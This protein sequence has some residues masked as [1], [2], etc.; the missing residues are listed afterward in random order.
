MVQ[1]PKIYDTFLG[2]LESLLCG[3]GAG[4]C[5]KAAVYPL[6]VVKKRLQIQGF[7]HGRV[8]FGQTP[9][10]QGFIHCM[11]KVGSEEGLRGLYKGLNPSLLKAVT[12]T[13]LHFFFYE[14]ACNVLRTIHTDR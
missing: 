5:A 4:L 12:S 8:G 11:R 2:G 10:Y 6:D 13:G 3:S 1:R 7:E 9:G 14:Q